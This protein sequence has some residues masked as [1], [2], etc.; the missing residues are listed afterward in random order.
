MV[1]KNARALA[2][3]LAKKGYKIVSGGTDCHLFLVDL[4]SKKLT[5]LEIEKTLD[6]AGITLN[7]NTIPYDTQKPF[8]AS[9]I[10][11]GTPSVTTRGMKEKEMRAIADFIDEA[12]RCGS[13]N[14]KRL[15]NIKAKVKMLCR[16]FPL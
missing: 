7:K 16:R 3:A 6:K 9:G 13:N 1:L 12:I 15:L 14:E 10:R 11:I 2:S 4:T 8:V 5:G